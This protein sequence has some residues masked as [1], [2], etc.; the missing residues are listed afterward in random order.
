MST[1]THESSHVAGLPVIIEFGRTD[2]GQ[3]IVTE[4]AV[5]LSEAM[6]GI[7]EGYFENDQPEPTDEHGKA[8]DEVLEEFASYLR[9]V[10]APG[11][12]PVVRAGTLPTPD[13]AA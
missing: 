3:L 8:I 1:V 7:T 2:T 10:F 5:D 13:T 11:H 12:N 9:V 4:I 6:D